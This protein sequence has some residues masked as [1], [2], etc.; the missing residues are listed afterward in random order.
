MIYKRQDHWHLDVTVNGVRY[1]EALNTTDRR[2]AKDLEKKR[3]AEIS[4]GKGASNAGKE[5]ARRSFS[6]AAD[7]FLDDRKP[8]VSERTHQ[9]E[10][11]L[12]YPLRRAFGETPLRR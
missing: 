8:H 1:R 5:F 4:Q 12:F 9:L 10:R 3:I 2:E 7:Q 6:A 11:N